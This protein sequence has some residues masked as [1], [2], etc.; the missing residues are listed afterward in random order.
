MRETLE[1]QTNFVEQ[2]KAHPLGTII[3]MAMGTLTTLI[4]R[5]ILTYVGD[6]ITGLYQS[7][8]AQTRGLNSPTNEILE[9][10][11]IMLDFVGE[12]KLINKRHDQ[13][14]DNLEKI[15]GDMS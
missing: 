10:K 8:Q 9:I 6:K 7:N 13:R 2:Y 12:Q 4:G 1:G 5:I 11:K 3:T 15:Q 14:L